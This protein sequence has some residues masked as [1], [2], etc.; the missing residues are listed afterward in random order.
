[1]ATDVIDTL[2]LLA[3]KVKENIFDISS[4]QYSI[5]IRDQLVRGHLLV[6][7][8]LKAHPEA[9]SILVVG[10]GIAGIAAAERALYESKNITVHVVETGSQAFSRQ[11]GVVGRFVGPF[12][13][14]WPAS[15]HD[16]QRYPPIDQDVWGSNWPTKL[17]LSTIDPVNADSLC[18]D[19]DAW[20]G[21]LQAQYPK[22]L[23]FHFG[24]DGTK[25]IKSIHAFLAQIRAARSHYN[26][27]GQKVTRG[28]FCIHRKDDAIID[29]PSVDYVILACGPGKEDVTLL[30]G[31][32]GIPFWQNDTLRKPA[33]VKQRIAIFGGGDGALQ[34]VLRAITKFD[35]PILMLRYLTSNQSVRKA[36]EAEYGRLHTAEAQTRLL[37][38]W[39]IDPAVDTRLDQAC[40]KLAERLAQLPKVRARL[41]KCVRNK[42][43]TF[44]GQVTHVIKGGTFDKAYL[45]NR[46]LVHLLNEAQQYPSWPASKIPY[47]LL[48]NSKAV[49]GRRRGSGVGLKLQTPAGTRLLAAHLLV[50][51]FGVEP[52]SLASAGKKKGQLIQL[53]N[54]QSSHRA[55]YAKV[56]LPF[57]V[58]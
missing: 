54:R 12:M 14:E 9:K 49:A 53:T 31:L 21:C 43:S 40:Q 44:R 26:A 36:V 7:D 4:G 56:Q 16:D 17:T 57:L 38:N 22:R 13:Y 42:S 34:D 45:L 46:F 19:L 24:A 25:T 29:R 23:K 20:V 35:H 37:H 8:L 33:T 39:T 28:T 30:R 6:R 10:A 11:R 18:S 52:G 32:S 48:K 15:S 3:L 58:P 41:A 2:S 47:L 27:N 1:M 50:V 51:R 55:S 5:S